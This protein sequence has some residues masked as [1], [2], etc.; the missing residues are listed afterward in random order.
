MQIELYHY[1]AL[2][3]RSVNED[4]VSCGQIN[5]QNAFAVVCDGLGGHGGGRDA[6]QIA[7]AAL[8]WDKPGLPSEEELRARL[9]AA[10]REI[11]ARRTNPR[12]MKTTAVALYLSGSQT[13]WCHVG[14][15]RLYHFYNGRLADFTEDHSVCQIAVRLGEITRREIPG[16]PDR[17]KILKA[18]G[19]E[20][21]EPEIHPAITL[22]RG[23]HAFLL[24]TDGLW[25]RL[26]EDE[27]MLDLHKAGNPE[28]WIS[29]LRARA[30]IRKHTEVDNNTA[31][32]LYVMAD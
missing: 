14:D 29:L 7:V 9:E 2:G 4:S 1:S 11:I 22:G 23:F 32:A 31:V 13:R 21:L 28:Q 16:H 20:D 17:S 6:S 3:N 8:N 5:G 26:Q 10:N 24:C 18:L 19:S 25:E 30:E 12:Q 27:I 15:S